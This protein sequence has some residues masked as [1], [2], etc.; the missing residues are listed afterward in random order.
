MK[1][2]NSSPAGAW[3][4][5]AAGQNL[6]DVLQTSGRLEEM[7]LRSYKPGELLL[8]PEDRSGEVFLIVGGRVRVYFLT[9]QGD[10][11]FFA[12]LGAGE[13]AGELSAID[14]LDPLTYFEA[15]EPTRA[16]ALRRSEFLQLLR[17]SPAFA[18][19]VVRTLCK[20]LRST[21]QRYIETRC[22][23]MRVRLYAELLRLGKV[24]DDGSVIIAPAPT[25][26]ELAKRIASQRETVTKEINSLSRSGIIESARQAIRI[27]KPAELQGE[28]WRVLGMEFVRNGRRQNGDKTAGGGVSASAPETE[29]GGRN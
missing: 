19:A 3:P 12:E 4:D 6:I 14:G 24:G 7:P 13:C 20:R 18:N 9:P 26:L 25:H 5:T 2:E 29:K 16:F 23:P 1:S 22:L 10:D 27:L 15:I 11:A 8:Q 28:I 17:A 21:N